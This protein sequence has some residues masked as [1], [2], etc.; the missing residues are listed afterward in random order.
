[1]DIKIIF[2][3]LLTCTILWSVSQQHLLSIHLEKEV[4]L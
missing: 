2:P 4:G 1:M 3:A